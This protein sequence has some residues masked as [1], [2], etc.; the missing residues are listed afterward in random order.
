MFAIFTNILSHELAALAQKSALLKTKL[1]IAANFG[2]L[3]AE[4]SLALFLH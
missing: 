2:A 1:L 4:A 3:K